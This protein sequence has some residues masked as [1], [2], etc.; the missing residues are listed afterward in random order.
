L[1]SYYSRQYG[2][3]KGD[4]PNAEAAYEGAISLPIYPDMSDGDVERVVHSVKR[5]VETN[6]SRAMIAI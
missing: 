4:F 1:H 5:I 2:Y 3:D 6:R